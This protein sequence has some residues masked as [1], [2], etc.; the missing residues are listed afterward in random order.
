MLWHL[1]WIRKQRRGFSGIFWTW[2]NFAS[3]NY[4]L[5]PHTHPQLKLE[6]ELPTIFEPPN[7]NALPTVSSQ[8]VYF[9]SNFTNTYQMHLAPTQDLF[10][11]WPFPLCP[12]AFSETTSREWSWHKQPIA[13]R[14]QQPGLAC[15]SY[16]CTVTAGWL[17]SYLP[18][19]KKVQETKPC[20]SWSVLTL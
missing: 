8:A 10:A 12:S 5:L 11:P 17:H 4:C 20:P 18:C 14:H 1:Q 2:I 7:N 15:N 9:T 6:K 3:I 16:S 13:S 19:H